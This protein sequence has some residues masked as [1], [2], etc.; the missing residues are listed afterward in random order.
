MRGA[1]G[2]LSGF[3]VVLALA[4]CESEN[5]AACN[6]FVA[7][8]QSLPCAAGIDPGVDCNAF[9]DYPCPITDYFACLEQGHTCNEE[10]ELVVD[11]VREGDGGP[12]Q[13]TCADLLD[14][15]R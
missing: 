7:H 15:E 10:G 8:H 9:A 1:A 3:V 13:S 2:L 4:A 12:G 5:A 11:V 14:C 6:S